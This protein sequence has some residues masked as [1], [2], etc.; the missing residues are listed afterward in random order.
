[1]RRRLDEFRDVDV[2]REV[3]FEV[4]GDAAVVGVAWVL[5]VQVAE[6]HFD[7]VRDDLVGLGVSRSAQAEF[8]AYG[9]LLHGRREGGKA[10]WGEGGEGVGLVEVFVQNR[11]AAGNLGGL[12]C[13]VEELVHGFVFGLERIVSVLVCVQ[14]G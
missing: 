5:D 3:D 2:G 4:H 10:C 8:A 6:R 1:M 14:V 7:N 12:G 13:G 11:N 9:P